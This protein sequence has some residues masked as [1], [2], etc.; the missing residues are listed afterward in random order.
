MRAVQADIEAGAGG[1]A[2][3]FH[4]PEG[5][6]RQLSPHTCAG[7]DHGARVCAVV[8]EVNQN[9]DEELSIVKN[10]GCTVLKVD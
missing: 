10:V 2:T 9:V 7:N 5:D 8:P 4:L 1:N 6:A 3:Q